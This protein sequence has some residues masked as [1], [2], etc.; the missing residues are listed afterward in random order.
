M[1]NPGSMNGPLSND[2]RNATG[3]FPP[4]L[5][6]AMAG[7]MAWGIRGQYGHETGAMLAGL[8]VSLTLVTLLCPRVS[9]IGAARAVALATV[10]MGFGGSMTYGQTVGLTHDPQ[11]VG[12]WAALGWGMLGLSIKGGLWIGFAG[13]FL[14]MGLGGTRYRALEMLLLML[15]LVAA[16]FAGVAL[17]NSPFDPAHRMLPALYFSEHWYWKPNKVLKPRFECW[18]GL[19]TALAVLTVYV[20]YWRRDRLARR[21]VWWGILGGA[22]GFPLGQSIQA[23]HA[24]NPDFLRGSLLEGTVINWWN[25]METTYGAVMGALL[26]CGLWL[27]RKR[28]QL[29]R[30]VSDVS[31]PL[32][33]E[34]ILLA[35]HLG[36]LILVEFVNGS[37]VETIGSPVLS[38]AFRAVDFLYD[39]GLVMGI[40]PILAIVGGRCWPYF[41]VFPVMLIPY[42]GKT[43]QQLVYKE[44]AV[45]PIVGWLVYLIVPLAVL[46]TI[47]ITY[48]R[49][50]P[51]KQTGNAFAR[52]ALLLSAWLYFLLNYAFFRFPWPWAQWTGRTPNGIIFT[53][54]VL[55]LTACALF[56]KPYGQDPGE[57]G[58]KMCRCGACPE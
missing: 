17:I 33:V 39:L 50:A 15:A 35:I 36:L 1:A 40:I 2:R 18:G 25:M 6:G 30:A 13:A 47:A 43:V 26:G 34:W 23:Y 48:A 21:L 4:V 8:L 38:E 52:R 10:A 58:S 12:N 55:S 22:L 20:G 19:L 41:T 46:T 37:V 7:G 54:C 51:E 24:W 16:Y 32:A 42:A 44:A 31:L 14:G 3:W 56:V 27:N 57:K 11:L 53:I 29:D 45:T 49:Q 5:F 9:L 28:I